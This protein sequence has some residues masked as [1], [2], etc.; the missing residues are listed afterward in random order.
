MKSK[1]LSK[2]K[3]FISSLEKE[4]LLKLFLLSKKEKLIIKFFN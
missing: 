4:E 1:K 2:S 3:K